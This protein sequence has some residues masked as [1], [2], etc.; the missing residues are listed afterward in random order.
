[1]RYSARHKQKTHD[2]IVAKAA[3]LFREEG[4]TRCGVDAVMRAARLTPGGFYAHFRDK[5]AL[6]A[7]ALGHC[8]TD[9]ARFIASAIADG[10][11][12]LMAWIDAY[13]NPEH[14]AAPGTGCPLPT[15]AGEIARQPA[16]VRRVFTKTVRAYIA[17]LGAL[18]PRRHGSRRS[19]AAIAT[20]ASL[21]G[22]VLLARAVDDPELSDR[23]LRVVRDR[24]LPPVPSPRVSRRSSPPA[25][26]ARLS[27]ARRKIVA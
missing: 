8:R 19:D 13:L 3:R 6:L 12:P 26:A 20:I 10:Q 16:K 14:L 15:L 17:T 24:S 11:D 7:E 22:A 9:A 4:Y 2:R 23:I 27:K 18:H 1:M 21:A 5:D 25:R